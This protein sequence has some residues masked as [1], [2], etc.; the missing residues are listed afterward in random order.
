[1]RKY[2]MKSKLSLEAFVLKTTTVD[3]YEV[4]VGG[5]CPRGMKEEAV[6]F[7]QNISKMKLGQTK[8][9]FLIDYT[10]ANAITYLSPNWAFLVG[11]SICIDGVNSN[12]GGII[13]NPFKEYESSDEDIEKIK[14]GLYLISFSGGPGIAFEG[15]NSEGIL[16]KNMILNYKAAK[17]RKV[18]DIID[19]LD[20]VTNLYVLVTDGCGPRNCG[21]IYISDYSG[22]KQETFCI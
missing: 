13:G 18:E 2:N 1:M 5:I 22:K 17:S 20:E 12:T 15:T 9:E 10:L 3:G 11:A 4:I 21:G 8:D 19:K 7:Y 14:E 6:K 16:L